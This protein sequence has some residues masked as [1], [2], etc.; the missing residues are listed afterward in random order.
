MY[1]IAEKFGRK[2]N[3]AVWQFT[4]ITA[5]LKFTNISYLHIC[6]WRSFTKP[7]NLNLPIFL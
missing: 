3:L 7:P 4:F 6:V 5:K 1:R 2:L